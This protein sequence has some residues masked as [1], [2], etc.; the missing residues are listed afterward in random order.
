MSDCALRDTGGAFNSLMELP[1]R[2]N[3]MPHNAFRKGYVEG[4]SSIRGIEHI[5]D[6]PA[7]AISMDDG[8]Y[9]AGVKQVIRDACAYVPSS[10][11][12]KAAELDQWFSSALQ[13]WVRG[14]ARNWP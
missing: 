12:T 11:I 7:T 10:G 1:C 4:W 3:A 9:R 6:I 13:R 2:G 8:P 14:A 5:S